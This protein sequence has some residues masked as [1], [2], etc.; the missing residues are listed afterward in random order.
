MR[1]AKRFYNYINKLIFCSRLLSLLRLRHPRSAFKFDHIIIAFPGMGYKDNLTGCNILKIKLVRRR[2]TPRCNLDGSVVLS[3]CYR[4]L[5]WNSFPLNY[6][7]Y[8]F[9][10][11]IP[12]PVSCDA[13]PSGSAACCYGMLAAAGVRAPGAAVA[14]TSNRRT[15]SSKCKF[16]DL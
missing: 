8:C 14:S 1:L 7:I 4:R 3:A 11:R 13:L 5:R 6:I 12:F 9:S 2:T 10:R 16:I 15:T